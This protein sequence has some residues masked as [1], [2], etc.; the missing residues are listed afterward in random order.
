MPEMEFMN[1]DVAGRVVDE[2]LR[3]GLI[4]NLIQGKGIRV[5]P[6]LNIKEEEMDEGLSLLERSV[7][8][9]LEG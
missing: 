5:I 2:C 9:V 8:V 4:V 1:E 6:V 3:N 7:K